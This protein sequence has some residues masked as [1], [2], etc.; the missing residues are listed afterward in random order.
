MPIIT[1][2]RDTPDA[3]HN[4]SSDQPDMKINT[5]SIDDL[6]SIDHYSFNDNNGGLHKQVRLVDLLVAPTGTAAGLGTLYTKLATSTGVSTE[7][8]L[9]YIPDTKVPP[10]DEYQL[11]RTIKNQFTK[12][13]TNTNYQVGPPS[14]FGGWTFLP[15]GLLF[16]YGN[17]TA[18]S[19]SSTTTI[20]FPIPFTSVFNIQIS[21]ESDGNST[22][23]RLNILNPTNTNFKTTQTATSHLLSVYWTAIGI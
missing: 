11:T 17:T 6:I 9:F 14:L 12:F 18:P 7:S 22:N 16:Q 20:T 21:G 13:A 4:P 1:Y 2:N 8:D 3:P 5:N 19:N 10:L 23:I 15:G